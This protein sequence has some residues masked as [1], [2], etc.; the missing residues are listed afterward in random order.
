MEVQLVH[1]IDRFSQFSVD[2][3]PLT[4][5][6][7]HVHGKDIA[8]LRQFSSL[9]DDLNIDSLAHTPTS[10]TLVILAY[11]VMPSAQLSAFCCWI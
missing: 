10:S 6:R 4:D 8:V 7:H 3:Y 11:C 2:C 9:E 5:A 1:N